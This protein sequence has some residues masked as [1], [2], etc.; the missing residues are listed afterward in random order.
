MFEERNEPKLTFLSG[1]LIGNEIAVY[2]EL[3]K[4]FIM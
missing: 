3:G 4:V 2:T 1:A